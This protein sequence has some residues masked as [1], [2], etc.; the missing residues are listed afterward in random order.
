MRDIKHRIEK[1]GIG[2]FKSS[3]AP[4]RPTLWF[5]HGAVG[6][7]YS[8]IVLGRGDSNLFDS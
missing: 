2:T 4:E 1:A 8:V 6:R 3:E 7:R 5:Y